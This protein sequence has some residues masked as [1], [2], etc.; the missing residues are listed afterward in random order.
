M[1]EHIKH[2][3][4]LIERQ[5]AEQQRSLVREKLLLAKSVSF[6]EETERLQEEADR[7]LELHVEERG[8]QQRLVALL[9]QLLAVKDQLSECNS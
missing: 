9:T 1:D 3:R 8:R 6:K 4:S 7:L 2:A 5:R